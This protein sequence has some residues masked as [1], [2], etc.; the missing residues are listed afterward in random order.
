MV[1]TMAGQPPAEMGAALLSGQWPGHAWLVETANDNARAV[2]LPV[3]R[4][5]PPR[6]KTFPDA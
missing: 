1:D 5:I 3:L 4:S 6:C 2:P